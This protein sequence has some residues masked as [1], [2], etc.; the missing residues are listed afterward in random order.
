MFEQERMIG[1]L[2]RRV[3]V[4]PTILACFLSGSF[5]RRSSDTFSDLDVA[6]IFQNMEA[7]EHAWSSRTPFAQSIMPYLAVKSFD[8]QHVRPYFHIALYANGSKLDFRYEAQ[9][10]L[11]PNP[12]DGQIRILK[13][14]QGWAETF[15]TASS[16][17]AFP[18]PMMSSSELVELDQR[19]WIMCW[20]IIRQLARGDS[21]HPFS[22][23]LEVLYFTLPALL[24]A[25][26]PEDT[27]RNALIRV[28]YD[29]NAKDSLKSMVDLLNAYLATRSAI[30]NRYSL[31]LSIENS[32]ELEIKNLL[33]KL[34]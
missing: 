28:S 9:D 31:Q 4:E 8:A 26:P 14:T 12:W 10:T 29:L 22:I 27:A 24:K 21:N 20:D 5:G 6:L 30:I 25:L 16:R 19:F 1:R 33:G 13:D 23:Y 2:Q 3:A 15:Q 34:I 18:Q 17:L 32:F 7:R 11:A